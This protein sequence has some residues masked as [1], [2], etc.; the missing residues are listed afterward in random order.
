MI[1]DLSKQ[2][3]I[4]TIKII[5]LLMKFDWVQKDEALM[6]HKDFRS[7][8]VI[9]PKL[10][11]Y[12]QDKIDQVHVWMQCRFESTEEEVKNMVDYFRGIFEKFDFK[13]FKD[14]DAHRGNFTLRKRLPFTEASFYLNPDYP[15]GYWEN[16]TIE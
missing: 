12:N 4:D 10:L 2:I 6:A 14:E 11:Y 16:H 8:V 13:P 3:D 7:G 1:F 15:S 5:K 9:F